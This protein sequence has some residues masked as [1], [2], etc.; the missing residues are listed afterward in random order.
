MPKNAAEPVEVAESDE[1]EPTGAFAADYVGFTEKAG[2]FPLDVVAVPLSTTER[3]LRTSGRPRVEIAYVSEEDAAE[4]RNLKWVR[5]AGWTMDAPIMNVLLESCKVAPVL[6]TLKFWN[7]GIH[8]ETFELLLAGLTHASMPI[9]QLYLEDNVVPAGKA[10]DLENYVKLVNFPEL[11]EPTPQPANTLDLPGTTEVKFVEPGRTGLKVLS[12]RGNGID[13]AGATLIG[14]ALN[15]NQTLMSL[16]LYRNKITCEGAR[17]VFKAL[18]LNRTLRSLSIGQNFLGDASVA[19]I[20][21]VLSEITLTHEETVM[22][23]RLIMA[24]DGEDGAGAAG[25]D[26]ALGADKG[27]RKSNNQGKAGASPAVKGGK[28]NERTPSAGKGGNRGKSG[29]ASSKKTPKTARGDDLPEEGL[30][31]TEPPKNPLLDNADKNKQGQWIISGNR[32]LANLNLAH[33]EISD[34]GLAALSNM[35]QYQSAFTSGEGLMRL[36]V[37][38]NVPPNNSEHMAYILG[39]M[40]DRDPFAAVQPS[41][42]ADEL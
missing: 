5:A 22:R 36:S 24:G 39:E 12:L 17:E 2:A 9:T 21:G 20:A 31:E 29:R 28:K 1:Y 42:P 41:D 30:G 25:A 13:D 16:V 4:G 34:V 35:L 40:A 8:N 7:S 19:E 11:A 32:S 37:H 38:G 6:T 14:K 18:R 15:E 3:Q 27:R 23:R 26:G 10:F 33:N